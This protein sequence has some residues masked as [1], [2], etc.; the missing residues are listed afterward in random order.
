MLRPVCPEVTEE[1]HSKEIDDL[2]GTQEA[3][4]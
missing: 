1:P 2:N 4:T 3:E